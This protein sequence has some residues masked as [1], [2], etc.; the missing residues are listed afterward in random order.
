[1]SVQMDHHEISS[2]Q[3][4]PSW[5]AVKCKRFVSQVCARVFLSFYSSC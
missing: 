1:L 4:L 5:N 2:G 3:L